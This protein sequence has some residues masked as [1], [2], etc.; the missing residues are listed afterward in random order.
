[1]DESILR[2]VAKYCQVGD[3]DTYYDPTL[4]LIINTH[5]AFLHQLGVLKTDDFLIEDTDR[6]WADVLV[7][8]ARMAPAILYV[9]IR[10]RLDFDPPANSF[11]V[12]SLTEKYKEI[13][14]RLLMTND[15]IEAGI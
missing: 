11:L 1:M 6:P 3:D 14:Q 15:D 8:D 12:N 5:L 10:S 13:E 4:I 9:Q 7:E 2:S